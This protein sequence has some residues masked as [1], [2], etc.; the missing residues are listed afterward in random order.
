MIF[1]LPFAV[2]A[3]GRAARV[4][5]VGALMLAMVSFTLGASLAKG[6][7][8]KVGPQGATSLRLIVAAVTLALLF[9]PWRMR[10]GGHWMALVAYG[11]ALGSMNLMFYMALATIPLGVAIAI[12]FT[13]PLALAVLTSRRK[14]EFLWIALAIAGLALLLPLDHAA[15]RLNWRGVALALGAGGCWAV[16]I[17]C[18]RRAVQRHGAATAS[19]GMIIAAALVAPVGVAQAG[20]RLLQPDVLVPGLAVGLLS[21]AIPYTLE[22]VALRRLSANSYG[23]LVSAEPAIGALMGFALLGEALPPKQWLAIGLVILSSAGV[24]MGTRPA[25]V[26]PTEAGLVEDEAPG[27]SGGG[28]GRDGAQA[29]AAQDGRRLDGE[30]LA[31]LGA[32]ID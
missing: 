8:P 4:I 28:E 17:L 32:E 7:F 6:L 12:E 25:R 29:P 21:S 11:V 20:M 22:M 15:T 23:T 19:A 13:G 9:R 14:S 3:A 1:R 27:G 2:P 10:L 18:A 16:Y 30:I 31:E 26:G 5:S 24:A